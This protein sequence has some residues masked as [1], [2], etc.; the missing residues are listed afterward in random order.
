MVFEVVRELNLKTQVL[1]VGLEH[2]VGTGGRRLTA[3]QRQKVALV[4]AMLRRPRILI[5]NNALAPMESALQARLAQALRR[6]MKD[7]ALV[8][9]T[10]NA[11]LAPGFAEAAVMKAGRIVEHGPVARLARPGSAL[12]E[13]GVTAPAE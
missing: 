6:E 1:S 4:R 7:R 3:V 5:L 12:A 13:F 9:M 8:L 2:N 10:E 11:A